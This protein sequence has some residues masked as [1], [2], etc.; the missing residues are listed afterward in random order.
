MIVADLVSQARDLMLGSGATLDRSVAL[1]SDITHDF[2]DPDTGLT[3]PF[4]IP[5][6]DVSGVGPCVVEIDF[7]RIRVKGAS[8]QSLAVYRFGRGYAGSDAAP[9]LS[10]AE[11]RINPVFPQS[12]I[13]GM[14]RHTVA[15]LANTLYGVRSME[16]AYEHGLTLPDPA[17]GVVAVYLLMHEG[18]T[19]ER[20]ETLD[21]DSTAGNRLLVPSARNG[22]TVRVVYAVHPEFDFQPADDFETFTGLSAGV[23]LAVAYGAAA[24]M[25]AAADATRAVT[26][27]AEAR[28][29]SQVRPPSLG[30]TVGRSLMQFYEEAIVREQARLA[31][32]FKIRAHRSSVRYIA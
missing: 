20:Q 8:G 7:E 28:A 5:V 29:D 18:V 4:L 19:W 23:G 9:H 31:N 6:D 14:M 21:W 1:T 13:L 27:S 32:D 11:V 24:K 3:V 17:F 10:G 15:G 2:V 12:A 25:L 16:G 26:N 30:T 22:Q